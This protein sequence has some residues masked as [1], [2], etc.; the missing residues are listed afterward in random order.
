MNITRGREVSMKQQVANSSGGGRRGLPRYAT[1]DRRLCVTV[2]EAAE[3]LGISRNF[4]Y[5]LVREGKLPSIR[6]GKRI[7]IPRAAL[8]KMLAKDD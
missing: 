3:M 5:Q 1:I 4:A 6:F 2:A 7:L 8:E